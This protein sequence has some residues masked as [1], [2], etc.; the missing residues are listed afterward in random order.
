[1]GCAA[2]NPLH[3][4]DLRARP[5]AELLAHP[6]VE[7]A[8]S[9]SG[10]ALDFLGTR[11]CIDPRAERVER[12]APPGPPPGQELQ[13]LLIRYLTAEL[14]GGLSGDL[15]SEKEL[16][17]GATFFRGPHALPVGPVIERFGADLD[18]FAARCRALGASPA[19][20]GDRGY[21]LEPLAGLVLIYGLW[22]ADE[23]FPA[24]AS[25]LLDRAL[26]R[27]FELDMI[28]LLIRQ[29]SLALAAV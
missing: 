21:R 14:A 10:Y 2:P 13:I 8:A 5:A 3:W 12:I 20:C 23:E 9:G 16:P 11:Y 7:P 17:G 26:A 1:M 15:I 19:D 22:R 4:Q 27:W 28:F 25:V 24:A 6:G 18:G 29:T